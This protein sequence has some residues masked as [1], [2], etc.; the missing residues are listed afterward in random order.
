M[1]DCAGGHLHLFGHFRDGS[2]DVPQRAV[3]QRFLEL[4]PLQILPVHRPD[5]GLSLAV[6]L[7]FDARVFLRKSSRVGGLQL[8][9]E[10]GH[11]L[12][13]EVAFGVGVGEHSAED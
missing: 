1:L 9:H 5:Y 10:V 7:P 3:K 12:S 2:T 6:V 13:V 4:L 8:Q 11:F